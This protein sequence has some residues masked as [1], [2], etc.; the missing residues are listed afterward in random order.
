MTA[1][2]LVEVGRT[3]CEW[4]PCGGTLLPVFPDIFGDDCL[5]DG[6]GGGGG[7][8]LA[9]TGRLLVSMETG[10]ETRPSLEGN[11]GGAIFCLPQGETSR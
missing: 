1:D 4:M 6:G 3:H 8:G 5:L 10:P 2:T 11:A 9:T 7:A